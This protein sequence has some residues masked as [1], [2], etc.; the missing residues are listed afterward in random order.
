MKT[1][2]PSEAFAP[3]GELWWELAIAPGRKTQKFGVERKLA[4]WLRFNKKVGDTFTT[5]EGRLALGE[6]DIP[7]ADEHFQ[8]RLRQLRK[9]GWVI[10]STKYDP[11]LAREQYRVDTIGWY[12]GC[13]V[14]R[15]KRPSVSASTKRKVFDRDGS[16][17]V[18]CGARSGE[19]TLDDP[20]RTVRLTVGHVLSDDYGGSADIRN[21]RSECSDCNEPMRSE[22]RKPES[23]EEIETAIRKLRT[24]QRVRLAQWIEAR[25]YIRD[26]AEEVYDRY[27]QLTPGDQEAV[28]KA[29]KQLAGLSH[30]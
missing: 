19:P 12:P 6:P 9:D 24:G 29:I 25:R 18:V 4:A 1:D 21:L 16:M 27:R 3:N 13:G 17:C 23:R 28:R 5:K 20:D 2:Y 7:N 14:D 15:P 26:D 10:P 8:R 30:T 11:S 22:G